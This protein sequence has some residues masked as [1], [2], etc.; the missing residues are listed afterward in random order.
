MGL[1]L[2]VNGLPKSWD[3]ALGLWRRQC[4]DFLVKVYWFHK[5]R[6][7]WIVADRHVYDPFPQGGI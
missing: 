2:V 3:A 7:G 1:F 5:G 4:R 6:A